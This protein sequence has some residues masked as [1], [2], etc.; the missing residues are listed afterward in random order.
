MCAGAHQGGQ[1]LFHPK[2]L[3]VGSRGAPLG[4]GNTYDLSGLPPVA[5]VRNEQKNVSA[6]TWKLSSAVETRGLDYF[7]YHYSLYSRE[8]LY[9]CIGGHTAGE[10]EKICLFSVSN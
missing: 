5:G 10:R 7:H 2:K 1:G 9:L 3:A 8:C 4:G 6:A